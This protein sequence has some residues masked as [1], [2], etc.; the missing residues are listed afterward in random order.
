MFTKTVG[1]LSTE[2][3]PLTASDAGDTDSRRPAFAQKGNTYMALRNIT[4]TYTVSSSGVSTLNS[5][6][7]YYGLAST[8]RDLA[9]DV[10]IDYNH[11]EPLQ[12]SLMGEFVTNMGFDRNKILARNPENNLGATDTSILGGGTAWIAGLKVGKFVL[13]KRWDWSVNLNYRNVESDAVIDGFC[14]SDFGGGGT[15]VK[16]F[17][18]GANVALAKRVTVGVR[19]MSSS[20]VSGP[21]LKNDILQ[22]DINGKF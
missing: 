12:I 14:D 7:Q 16:G 10:R 3:I 13:Q 21:D 4:P 22:F 20:Q 19:W 11:F 5:Q 8:F 15:N 17:T 2:F 1:K 9:Y 18:V 6:W